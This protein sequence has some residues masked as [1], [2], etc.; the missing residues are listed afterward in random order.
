MSAE[1]NTPLVHSMLLKVKAKPKPKP[2]RK[3]T[4]GCIAKNIDDFNKMFKIREVKDTFDPAEYKRDA[5]RAGGLS[6]HVK[7]IL[8]QDSKRSEHQIRDI[9]VS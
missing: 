2:Q 7:N 9:N 3:I 6:N 5:T 4:P 1:S 8:R